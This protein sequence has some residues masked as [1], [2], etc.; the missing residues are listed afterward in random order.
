MYRINISEYYAT[1]LKNVSRFVVVRSDSN[2]LRKRRV[3]EA[4]TTTRFNTVLPTGRDTHRTKRERNERSV[5]TPLHML[6][7]KFI[8]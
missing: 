1:W 8:E 7:I 3:G 2:E 5:P 4:F 6:K